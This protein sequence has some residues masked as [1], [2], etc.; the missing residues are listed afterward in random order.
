M[1]TIY[2][3]GMVSCCDVGDVGLYKLVGG[4]QQAFYDD[5]LPRIFPFVVEEE[6]SSRDITPLAFCCK[7]PCRLPQEITH[8]F[9]LAGF[10]RSFVAEMRCATR[11]TIHLPLSPSTFTFL[12]PILS[13]SMKLVSPV[14]KTRFSSGSL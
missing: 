11:N 5:F 12:P 2:E 1:F 9:P 3:K 7:S 8:A 10:P 13:V 14:V 4:F 6:R